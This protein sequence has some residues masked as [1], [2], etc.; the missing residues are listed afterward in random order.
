MADNMIPA[1]EGMQMSGDLA[2]NWEVFCADFEDFVLA[3]GINE[4]T[5]EVQAAS[6]RRLMGNE[7]RHI[8]MHNVPSDD[9]QKNDPAAILDALGEYF[10]PA[11]NV[12]YERYKFGCC[13]RETDE[14]IDSFL[15]RL[16]EGAASCEYRGLK[17][18][19]IRD[20]LVLGVASENT[21]RRLLRERE[22]TLSAAVEKCR[23]AE[24]TEKRMK[25]MESPQVQTDSVN[26]A[27]KQNE[28]RKTQDRRGRDLQFACKYCGNSHKRGRE[29][30][31]AYVELLCRTRVQTPHM[32]VMQCLPPRQ[33]MDQAQHLNVTSFR[34]RQI[35]QHT[36]TDDV[37]QELKT[38]ILDGWPDF[39]EDTPL[40]VRD[41][42]PFWDEL[43]A[44]WCAIQR[45]V[46]HYGWPSSTG[47]TRP[48]RGW[49]AAPLNA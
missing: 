2:K 35:A 41:Y 17:D 44:K 40:A 38:V 23:L 37:L 28:R 1:P 27:D 14:P 18:E 19:M 31:P 47:A 11:K 46:H 6:L 22:L 24:L 12:I 8:Y 26:A 4:K 34:F 42:W 39:K 36:G 20:R 5:E 48:Q 13:K 43:T 10:K 21:R 9:A 16:R 25:T 45:T 30:C 32:C 29:Q 49:T 33:R 3:A 15:T 7:C